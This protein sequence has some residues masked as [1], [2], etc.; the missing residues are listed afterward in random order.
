MVPIIPPRRSGQ[1]DKPK[2]MTKKYAL[3]WYR[4][5]KTM[6]W[7]GSDSE[8]QYIK[9][10]KNTVGKEQIESQGYI[11]NPVTYDIDHKG[12][13]NPAGIDI[14]KS[15]LAL[16]CSF[17][18]GTGLYLKDIWPTKLGELLNVP[19]Y[20]AGV[21]GGSPDH[22]YRI[23][24][25]LIPNHKPKAVFIYMPDRNRT[26]VIS[27]FF[28]AGDP[29]D[30]STWN[31]DNKDYKYYLRLTNGELSQQLQFERNKLA[32]K[33]L[34]RKEH[35]PCIHVDVEYMMVPGRSV[36]SGVAGPAR[37][38]Q[39]AGPAHHIQ[40]ASIFHNLYIKEKHNV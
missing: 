6:L 10:I 34:C 7:E 38:L 2:E 16:G 1:L 28:F 32:I 39:H 9:N 30:V 31:A 20:N 23:A 37:D 11:T 29:H 17:T 36:K 13:R 27:D 22:C 5:N 24:R 40:I 33:Q 19:V 14:S 8:E 25:D 35:I 21:G 12:F 18:F 3:T 15:I 26:E 4:P